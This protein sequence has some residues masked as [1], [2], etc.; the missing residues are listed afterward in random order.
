MKN[1][2]KGYKIELEIDL[3]SDWY[4]EL[5]KQM[6][7]LNLKF[8]ETKNKS[9][10][11]IEYI[12]FLRKRDSGKKWKI[13]KS[14]EF[15]CPP[16]YRK[17]LKDIENILERG[18]D[19]YP[20]LS[21][22]IDNLNYQDGLFNDWGV[23]HLHLGDNP[24]LTKQGFI[25]RTGPLLFLYKDNGVA[26]FLDIFNHSDWT[27]KKVLQII[28]N[29]WPEVLDKYRYQGATVITSNYS[30]K[31]HDEF[32][33]AGVIVFM[34]LKD[35]NG[36]PTVIAPSHLGIASSG[37]ANIDVRQHD[38]V[39]ERIK[40][41]E[42]I[43]RENIELIKEKMQSNSMIIPKKLHIKFTIEENGKLLISEKNTGFVIFG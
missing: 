31:E 2:R 1:E 43:I 36:K 5:I 35:I 12:N 11:I 3:I 9:T 4:N 38:Y 32:R 21:T 20:Y 15:Y 22:S 8:D 17:A 16:K 41:M 23:I 6:K 37:H 24:H 26:Y 30:E 25:S 42:N 34:E 28:Q 18:G 13:C 33:K 7:K 40:K 19:I 10:L 27:N 29:N 14:K 39:Y